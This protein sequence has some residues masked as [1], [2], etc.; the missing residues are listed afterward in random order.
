MIRYDKEYNQKISRV[1][2]NFNRKVRRLEKEGAELLPSTASVREIKAMFTNRGDLNTYLKHLQRFGERGAEDIVEIKG[3]RFTKYDVKEFQLALRRERRRL[4]KLIAEE[5]EI[6]SK[7]PLQHQIALENYKMRR[8]RLSSRS[9]ELILSPVANYLN[10]W[11]RHTIT[12]DNYLQILFQ[13]AYLAD[14]DEKKL[15]YIRS[16]LLE[17]SP[18]KFNKAL[19]NAPEI[20]EIFNYYHSLTRR[21]GSLDENEV[22][23]VYD[24]LYKNI[25][26]IVKRYK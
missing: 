26:D 20:Q 5:S 21:K 6:E 19:E 3:E 12:Y 22:K 4:D 11:A 8:A 16:K 23:E 13:D 10:D 14:Y 2:S 9:S 18:N 7:Y 1:V 24:V 25:D 17:L 15:D